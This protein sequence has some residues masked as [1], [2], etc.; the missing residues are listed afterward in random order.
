MSGLRRQ[1]VLKEY[2]KDLFSFA[3]ERVVTFI[4]AAP[5]LFGPQFPKDAADHLEQVVALKRAKSLSGH[6]S[7]F[8]RLRHLSD[9]AIDPTPQGKDQS[10]IQGRRLPMPERHLK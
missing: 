5:L 1:K 4:K 9:Q 2:N 3:K 10:C 7:G 6:G 8:R